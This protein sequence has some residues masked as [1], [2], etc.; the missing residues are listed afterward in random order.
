MVYAKRR[1]VIETPCTP[2]YTPAMSKHKPKKPKPDFPLYAHASGKWAKKIDQKVYYFGRWEDPD[3]ALKQ[4]LAEKD[5]LQAGVVP[6]DEDSRLPLHRAGDLFRA[7][8]VDRCDVGEITE[9]TLIDYVRTI[10]RLIGILGRNR[11]VITLQPKD[12]Q[13][14]RM[15]LSRTL[16][17]VA[18]GNEINRTRVFFRWL[19]EADYIAKPIKFGTEF[20]RPSKKVL[21]LARQSKGKRMFEAEELQLLIEKS[22]VDLKAMIL[23]AINGGL[24]QSDLA[25]M[26]NRHIDF[27]TGWVNFPRPKTGIERRFP[28]WSETT[29]AIREST[30]ARKEPIEGRNDLIFVTKRGNAWVREGA[31]G[32]HIDSISKVFSKLRKECEIE[33]ENK[34]FYAI[35]HTFQTIADGAKDPVAASHIMGHADDSMSAVYRERVDDERL[36]DV[37]EYV[38][39]WLMN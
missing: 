35:R 34:G 4:Y 16:G 30:T 22:N 18:L 11:D 15:K 10:K 14:V 7:S 36:K 20:K 28:L 9:R 1:Q 32:S 37:V 21:R 3:E 31:G 19:Y 25:Q 13:R 24:G 23:L 27:K 29:K 6:P 2:G 26:Q 12:F 17:P 5:Y 33:S 38:Q 39:S 8:K